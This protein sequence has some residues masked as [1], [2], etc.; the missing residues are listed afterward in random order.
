M[1][2]DLRLQLKLTK[3]IVEF[4]DVKLDL[5]TG[6]HKLYS[7]PNNT[8][9]YVNINS[10]HPQQVTNNIPKSINK[11]LSELSSNEDTF[12]AAA[13]DYQKALNE[14]GYNFKLKYSPPIANINEQQNRTK[15][16]QNI[17]WYNPPFSKSVATNIGKIFL[18]IKKK[19]KRIPSKSQPTQNL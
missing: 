10:N 4:L 11:R 5:N 6:K 1:R 16:K 18:D 2:T 7:K 19:K 17:T 12:N 13:G 14:S 8:L 15:R 9:L 3:K